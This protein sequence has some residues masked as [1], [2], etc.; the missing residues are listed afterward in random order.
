[1]FGTSDCE[2]FALMVFCKE[3]K[4]EVSVCEH[5]VDPIRARRISVF[6]PKIE[7]LAYDEQQ[8]ILEIVFKSGQVWQ[9]VGVPPEIY[10]EIRDT[11]ISSFLKFMAKRYECRP[12]KTGTAAIRVPDA[13]PCPKCKHPMTVRHRV[14]S[15]F[16]GVVRVL[17]ECQP[18]N[19]AP[20]MRYGSG[21][22][23]ERK[24]RWH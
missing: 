19:H 2:V 18:C 6:D 4:Q 11:S 3:C 15:E 20:W 5:F 24:G 10:G 8:R 1:M 16:D 23:R 12:V 21:S 17:W 14:N 22:V 7:T 13:E 9:L